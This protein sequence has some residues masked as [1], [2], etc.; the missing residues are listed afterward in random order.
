MGRKRKKKKSRNDT[1]RRE[2]QRDLST[3]TKRNRLKLLRRNLVKRHNDYSMI[4]DNRNSLH[5]SQPA[6]T[7]FGTPAKIRERKRPLTIRKHYDSYKVDN[8]RT[9]I[10]DSYQ[11]FEAPDRV[12]ECR[13]RKERREA[14]FAKG[15]AGKGKKI[16]TPKK[17]TRYSDIGC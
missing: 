11:E 7:I 12:I 15:K 5:K 8:R 10:R 16:R 3:I 9:N 17:F 14:L 6:K 13:R 1:R 4:E 2:A